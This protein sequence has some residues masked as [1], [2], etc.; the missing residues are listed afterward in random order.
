MAAA[1]EEK[2]RIAPAIL[3]SAAHVLDDIAGE[4]ASLLVRRP[5]SDGTYAA[6]SHII[7]IRHAGAPLYV[8]HAEVDV[9]AL[10]VDLPDDVVIT[11]LSP[12]FLADDE[13]A[14]TF[15][16]GDQIFC[17][18]FPLSVA[19]P[20]G[21]PILRM[22]YIASYPLTPLRFVK[23]IELDISLFPGN[24]GGPAYFFFPDA[25]RDGPPQTPSHGLLGLVV[26]SDRYSGP[27]FGNRSV[28]FGVILPAPFIRDAIE[29]LQKR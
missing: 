4:T 10:P 7:R 3:V 13:I 2:D 20:G 5:N 9:A 23:Q 26:Q 8:K 6:F 25:R 19:T 15:H 14:K 29:L 18:G 16:P 24:S 28:T 17:L 21:F 1:R 12:E 11:G 22:G 27:E